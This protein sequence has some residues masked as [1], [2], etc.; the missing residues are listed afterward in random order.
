MLRMLGDEVHP[1]MPGKLTRQHR[2][3]GLT[4]QHWLEAARNRQAVVIVPSK[5]G[6][7]KIE[8]SDFAFVPQD[9]DHLADFLMEGGQWLAAPIDPQNQAMDSIWKLFPPEF[10][11]AII[12]SKKQLKH[13]RYWWQQIGTEGSI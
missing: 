5:H 8:G 9:S 10:C 3:G 11:R 4:T 1:A 13:G 12:G 2:S 6:F 7:P